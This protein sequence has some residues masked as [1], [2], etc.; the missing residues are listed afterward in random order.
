MI[1]IKEFTQ[2]VETHGTE[3]T[4][5]PA[6]LRGECSA[7][8][9]N[10]AAARSLIHQQQKVENLLDQI[11][12]PDFPTLESRVVNQ[13]LPKHTGSV[14]DQILNWLLPQNGLGK[15]IWRPA[16]VACLPLMFGIV[17]GNFYSFGVD[18]GNDGFAYWDD[19]LIMLSLND[20][21]E[22]LF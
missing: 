21:T 14:F 11:I 20:Y 8:V 1:T 3:P 22:N 6:E 2:I 10:S 12:A 19:E 17:I 13:L 7:F 9:A 5:W 18:L 4:H 16:M 15:N